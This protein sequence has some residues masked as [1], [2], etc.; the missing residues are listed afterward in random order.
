MQAILDKDAVQ[1]I[2]AQA[3]RYALIVDDSPTQRMVLTRFLR[4]WGYVTVEATSGRDALARAD[5]CY[6][7]LILSDWMMPEMNGIDFCRAFR[8]RQAQRYSYF[9]LLTSKKD[10][11]AV[12]EGLDVGA[13]DFLTKPVS[14]VELRARIAAGERLLSMERAV[15][16]TNAEL[17]ATLGELQ[18]VHAAL[19]R[20]LQEARKLQLSLLPER[21]RRYDG[22]DV[23][24]LLE[25]S[26]PVGGDV[27]GAFQIGPKRVAIYSIDVSGHGVAAAMLGARVAALFSDGAQGLNIAMRRDPVTGLPVVLTPAQVA[28][29]LN[30]I[31]LSEMQTENYLT[32]AYLDLDL[33]SGQA[34]LVQAGH[35]H[36]ILQRQ[37]G[38]LEHLGQGGLPVGLLPGAGYD[39]VALTLHSGDRLLLHSDGITECADGKG[40]EFG[41]ARLGQWMHRHSNLRGL[42]M[43]E[44]LRW[45]VAHWAGRTEFTDDV[46][47]TIVEL[48]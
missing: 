6:F 48:H 36:P 34:R 35:P 41:Q 7:D 26:G 13:D 5:E 32:M 23:A 14:P 16:A 25:S 45:D 8:A 20:D 10:R 2:G 21:E 27:V 18:V 9:I 37:D 1:G 29:R 12:A 43:L 33:A 42:P 38:R 17:R 3:Q 15:Q 40:R 47:G 44:A 39:D 19:E 22:C 46:S 30:D 4:N 24:F 28:A 31:M 11:D